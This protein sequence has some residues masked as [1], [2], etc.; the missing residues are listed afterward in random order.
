MTL[1]SSVLVFAGLVN[2]ATIFHM[3]IWRTLIKRSKAVSVMLV[4]A[5]AFLTILPAHFHFHHVELASVASDGATHAHEHTVDLHVYSSGKNSA[6]P[7][8]HHD[9]AQILKTSPDGLIKNL[10]FKFSPFLVF[11][12]LLAFAALALNYSLPGPARQI[13]AHVRYSYHRSP[14]LRGPPHLI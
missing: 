3:R 8:S 13:L 12:S 6:H 2:A 10:D 7:F 11:I 4:I 14:P 9:D 1:I 5:L